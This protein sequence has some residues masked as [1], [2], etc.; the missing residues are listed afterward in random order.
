M[1]CAQRGHDSQKAQNLGVDRGRGAVSRGG[2]RVKLWSQTQLRVP[3]PAS[4]LSTGSGLKEVWP[5][6]FAPASSIC[7]F[8][9]VHTHTL[10]G[11][12]PCSGM[13]KAWLSQHPVLQFPR[14]TATV[15]S[16]GRG[17][18]E[19]LLRRTKITYL[20]SS[21]EGS[22]EREGER[23]CVCHVCGCIQE[24]SN[25]LELEWLVVANGLIWMLRT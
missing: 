21:R 8:T 6:G 9:H 17:E 7:A 18:W 19:P 10:R 4:V 11:T 25:P 2:V 16:S 5:P 13:R 3:L 24:A 1:R 15:K 12:C 14:A 20:S 22:G 23:V